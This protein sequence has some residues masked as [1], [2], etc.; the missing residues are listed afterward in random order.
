M[1]DSCL[2][3]RRSVSATRSSTHRA[4]APRGALRDRARGADG[5]H[6]EGRRPSESFVSV[7]LS[8]KGKAAGE[9]EAFDFDVT[10]ERHEQNSLT[11][12]IAVKVINDYGDEVLQVFEY[13]QGVGHP[14]RRGGKPTRRHVHCAGHHG[15]GL[16]PDPRRSTRS[17][18]A[19]SH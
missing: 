16:L 14:R 11:G 4:R 2:L 12:R 13:D 15:S 10:Q 3:A 8:K 5:P 19:T 6:R 1:S 18:R 7:P 9:Q 17:P